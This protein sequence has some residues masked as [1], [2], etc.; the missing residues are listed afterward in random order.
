MKSGIIIKLPASQLFLL[1][2][3]TSSPFHYKI[4]YICSVSLHKH[5]RKEKQTTMKKGMLLLTALFMLVSPVSAAEAGAEAYTEKETSVFTAGEAA[6][7]LIL[8][9][10]EE[11]PDIPYLGISAYSDY[12]R[13]QTLTLQENEDGTCSLVND[14]GVQILCDAE[15]GTIYAEDWNGFFDLPMPLENKALG[16]KDSTSGYV[17]F[18]NVEYEGECAPVTLDF[19]KYGIRIYAD[20]NDVYLPVSTLSN[21]MTDIATNHM[22]YNGENLYIGRLDLNGDMP[23]DYWDSERFQAEFNGQDRPED[24]IKQSYADLC[25]N[26]DYFFGHPGKALLDE[27]LASEGLDKAI[28]SLGEQGQAIKEGLL[29]PDL[30]EYLNSMNKLFSVYLFDGHTVFSGI[31]SLM[32]APA[33][34]DNFDFV[35]KFGGDLFSSILDSPSMLTQTLHQFITVQRSS[36]WGDEVYRESGNTAIIRLDSFMPDEKAWEDYY[37]GEGEFPQDSFG[38]VIS[39]LRKAAENPEIKNVL[40]DLSCNAG[41]SPDVLMGI[42]AVTTG[43]NQLYGIHKL[44]GQKM[45][46]TFEVDSNFDGVFDEKDQ[47]VHYDF[48]YGVLTTRQ[49]FSC[50]NL[51][52]IIIREGGAVVIGEPT[53]GGSCCIQV[54]TDAD[55]FNYVMS[56]CQWQLTDSEGVDVEGGCTVD[57]PIE[58]VS[59]GILDALVSIVGVTEGVPNFTGYFDE[60]MLDQM[61]NDYFQAGQELADAA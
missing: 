19:A 18:A 24:I 1:F 30:A 10:Y 17:R 32:S 11:T 34:K 47:E 35:S 37:S 36:I 26:F 33:L 39:G 55:G 46:F 7:P 40:F 57:L 22:L 20:Q 53:S 4:I 48:N 38:I 8:R 29:S 61:M 49:A 41:G 23:E 13:Q 2:L 59:N 27:A 42:L 14:R 28:D 44:T 25:F 6:A 56:S 43:Q 3:L 60:A 16:W 50:G 31:T 45:I 58:P 12:L 51:C 9:F 15:A 21:M 5:L 54:G 52:P